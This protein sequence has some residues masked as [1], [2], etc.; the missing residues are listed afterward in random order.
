M[1]LEIVEKIPDCFSG[2]FFSLFQSKRLKPKSR[3]DAQICVFSPKTG[4]YD[5]KELNLGLTILIDLLDKSKLALSSN[6]TNK[7]NEI[8]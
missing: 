1:R 4:Y 7:I 2:K 3:L 6:P 8:R 5:L